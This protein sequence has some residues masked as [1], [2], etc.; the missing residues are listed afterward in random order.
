MKRMMSGNRALQ[1]ELVGTDGEVYRPTALGGGSA[2]GAVFTRSPDGG[3]SPRGGSSTS[4]LNLAFARLPGDAQPKSLVF[5]T[6]E[7]LGEP[8]R[9]PFKFTDIP[10]GGK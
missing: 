3:I 10:V 1:A 9:I 2:S 6:V 4:R 7:R 5:R 8:R